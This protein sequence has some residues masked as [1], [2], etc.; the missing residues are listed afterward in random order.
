[1]EIQL[2][3]GKLNVHLVSMDRCNV[4]RG[5]RQVCEMSRH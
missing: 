3:A 1:M 4:L 2:S 5:K